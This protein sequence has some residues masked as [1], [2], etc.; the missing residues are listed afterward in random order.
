MIKKLTDFKHVISQYRE[1]QSCAKHLSEVLAASSVDFDVAYNAC[2]KT[3][4]FLPSQKRSEIKFLYDLIREHRC[5]N[6]CEIGTLRGGTLIMLCQA[7]PNDAK[8]VSVDMISTI[9]RRHALRNFTKPGQ[10]LKLVMGDSHSMMVEKKV[11]KEFLKTNLDFLFID[12]DHSLFGVMNDFVR[13]SPLVKSGGII[14]FHDIHPD[15]FIRT[16]IK[17]SSYVGGVPYF[18]EMIKKQGYRTDQFIED[19]SQDGYGIGIIYKE[20]I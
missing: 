8:I 1:M 15:S 3:R 11:Q 10:K 17:T 12:G 20:S 7:A 5:K 14:A 16:G 9:T 19:P 2:L 13:Y 4:S 18:W 6:I